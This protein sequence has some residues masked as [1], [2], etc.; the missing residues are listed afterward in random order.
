MIDHADVREQLELAAVQPG[1]LDR[2]TAGDTTE[3]AALAGHLAGCPSCSAEADRLRASAGLIRDAVLE[4]PPPELRERTIELIR[5]V[6]RARAVPVATPAPLPA[7]LA[8]DSVPAPQ[9]KALPGGAIVVVRRRSFRTI[10]LPLGIAAAIVIAIVGTAAVVGNR[11]DPALATSQATSAEL[12][13]VA[14]WTLEVGAESDVQRI[15]LVSQ[16]GS[17]AV[18]TLLFSPSTTDLV[19]VASGL[20]PAPSGKEYRCWVLLNGTRLDVGRMDVG[21]GLAY[22]VGPVAGLANPPA[23]TPFGVSLAEING[24]IEPG[25]PVIG[26]SF[27]G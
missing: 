17:S 3:A 21:G 14:A 24:P 4:T 13:R 5:A 26:G 10:A 8:P 23:G 6:G 9:L 7:V 19:V 11:Q 22:W 2:L 12:A 20:A 15:A 16:T 1:G 25:N 18:G 27:G